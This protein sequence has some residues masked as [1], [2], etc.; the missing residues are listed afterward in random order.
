MS[1][2][3]SALEDGLSIRAARLIDLN[4]YG[5]QAGQVFA[6][7]RTALL[8]FVSEGQQRY[9]RPSLFFYTDWYSWQNPDAAGFQSVLHHFAHHAN[10]SCID[11]A[12]F[13]DSVAFLVAHPAYSSMVE[14]LIALTDG[15]DFS[16]SPNLDD[17][18]AAL[19]TNQSRVHNAITAGVIRRAPTSRKRLVWVQAGPRFSTTRWFCSN[20]PR[21]WDL[22]C[23]WHTLAGLDLR[24]GEIHLRQSG[25]KFTAIYNV[26]C[27]DPDLFERY[28]QIL[29]LDDD[30]TIVHADIDALFDVAVQDGLDIFQASLLPGS[31]CVWPDLFRRSNTGARRTTGV[32]IMMPG[33]TRRALFDSAALFGRSVSGFGLDFAISERL[34][35]RGGVCGVV[36]AVSV[37]HYV[38]IDEQAGT[39]YKF[40]RALGINQKLEL[41]SVI[42]SLGKLPTFQVIASNPS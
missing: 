29:F 37:G 40:L 13:V 22:M 1:T 32:E 28:D 11:P 23:N 16:L 36:D 3:M 10:D 21:T 33:F 39:Y 31:F 24:H 25:T 9:L 20:A 4:Y 38:K 34:R 42:R 8:H 15:S 41:Y 14:A 7:H 27:H 17:H 19:A 26:L 18:L 5:S 35:Q 6:D 12:P 30:L 2:S